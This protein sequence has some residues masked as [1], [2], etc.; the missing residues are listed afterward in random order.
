MTFTTKSSQD[1]R[2]PLPELSFLELTKAIHIEGEK[3][4]PSLQEL[5]IIIDIALNNTYN[6]GL[7]EPGNNFGWLA[8][9]ESAK[10]AK[11]IILEGITD[12]ELIASEVHEGWNSIALADY[13]NELELDTPTTDE[14]KQSRYNL[15]ILNYNQLSDEEKEKDRVVARAVLSAMTGN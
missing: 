1:N 4:G 3:P 12:I 8:N 9:L 6:Y 14:K 5:A 10:A 11:Q 13:N 15:A 7:T 2:E